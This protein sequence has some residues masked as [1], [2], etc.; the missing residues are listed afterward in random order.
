ITILDIEK[1]KKIVFRLLIGIF[2]LCLIF[3]TSTDLKNDIIKE[4]DYCAIDYERKDKLKGNCEK[5]DL[6]DIK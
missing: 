3:R 5:I 6:F 2:I 4:I 1:L